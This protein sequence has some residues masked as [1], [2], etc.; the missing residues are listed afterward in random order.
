MREAIALALLSLA[1]VAPLLVVL[2][3][4]HWADEDSIQALAHLA[5]RTEGHRL[6]IAVTYRHA[7]ARERPEVWGLLRSLD[8]RPSCARLSL[9]PCSPG[10]DRGTRAALPGPRRGERRVLPAGPS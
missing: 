10:P 2:E 1:D 5:G 7:E 6:V 3:D 4:V 8:R 9:S